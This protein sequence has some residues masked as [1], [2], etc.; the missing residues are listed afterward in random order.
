VRLRRL[1]FGALLTLLATSHAYGQTL[2]DPS[3]AAV[4][5][6]PTLAVAV[7][8][9]DAEAPPG[10]RLGLV[11]EVVGVPVVLEQASASEQFAVAQVRLRSTAAVPLAQ[12]TL[13]ITAVRLASGTP[14]RR[15][16]PIAVP[17]APGATQ[18]V[19]VTSV[20]AADLVAVW[21]P[22]ESGALEVAV[23]GATAIDGFSVRGDLGPPP[24]LPTNAPVACGDA[25]WGP[26]LPGETA[27]D[28]MSGQLLA[29]DSHGLWRAPATELAQ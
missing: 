20:S 22:G 15:T 18:T 6:V 1:L 24:F 29:C 3:A 17:L 9:F 8:P 26:T 14:V 13:A 21:V 28:P 23:I 27:A 11:A 10:V 19:D 16:I 5:S 25:E 2:S 4:P 7:Q 12:V